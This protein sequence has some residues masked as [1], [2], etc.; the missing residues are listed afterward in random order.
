[1]STVMNSIKNDNE[2]DNEWKVQAKPKMNKSKTSPGA[3]RFGTTNT[4]THKTTTLRDT[5]KS[6]VVANPIHLSPTK[7]HFVNGKAKKI[8]D[9]CFSKGVDIR[10]IFKQFD[11]VKND[12]P[13]KTSITVYIFI[14]SALFD[15][16]K[17]VEYILDAVPDRNLIVN[18]KSGTMAYSAIFKAAYNGSIGCIKML[19]AANADLTSINTEGETILEALEQGLIDEIKRNPQHE[20]FTRSRFLEC[21][22]F[23]NNYRPAQDKML[24]FNKGAWKRKSDDAPKL[25]I[26]DEKVSVFDE[27]VSVF[28]E[29]LTVSDIISSY[30]TDKVTIQH[31][32]NSKD[33]ISLALV[34]ILTFLFERGM[35]EKYNDIIKI[36]KEFAESNIFKQNIIDCINDETIQ[37]LIIDAPYASK[38]LKIISSILQITK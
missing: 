19:L 12:S 10:D 33:D 17:F 30:S 27:K 25:S 13:L 14:Q 8:I 9:D 32:L 18:T 26:S 31:Y 24:S 5:T 36:V 1:M 20:L 35:T 21:K 16:L 22:E 7:V 6:N 4:A 29:E 3:C 38:E 28:D 2:N 34:E 11:Y 23:I 15:K 37:D